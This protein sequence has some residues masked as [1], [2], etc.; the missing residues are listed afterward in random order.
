M[1]S[2]VRSGDLK[3]VEYHTSGNYKGFQLKGSE[4]HFKLSGCTHLTFT[5]G[6]KE[7]FA[8]GIFC[9]EAYLNMFNLIDKYHERN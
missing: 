4:R 5:N 1:N 8:S 9:E 3:F 7:I 6:K 2:K